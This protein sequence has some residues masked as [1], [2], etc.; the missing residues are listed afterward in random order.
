VFSSH[1]PCRVASFNNGKSSSV[2]DL[3]CFSKFAAFASRVGKSLSEDRL[4]SALFA[5]F[6]PSFEKK[7]RMFVFYNLAKNNIDAKVI[8]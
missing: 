4:P 6:P 5:G 3:S 8:V 7:L 2:A 1:I